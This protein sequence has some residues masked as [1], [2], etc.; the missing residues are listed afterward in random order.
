VE[1][2]LSERGRSLTPV[3]HALKTWGDAHFGL[4]GAGRQ[5]A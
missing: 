1:Y 3:L 4:F 5:A 2:S